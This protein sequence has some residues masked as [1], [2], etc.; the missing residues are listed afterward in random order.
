MTTFRSIAAVADA[1]AVASADR[2]RLVVGIVG[3]PGAGKSTIAEALKARIG[4]TAIVLPMDGFHLHPDLLER[5]G[6][7]ER[8]GA[9]DT[10]N[11]TAF[12]STLA[13]V[14][15]ITGE[16][17]RGPTALHVG[18][19]GVDVW[20]PGFN[21]VTE[22]PVQNAIHITPEFSTVIVEGN[23][24]LLESGGW[25][26]VA[27]LLDVTFFVDIDRGVRLQRL[28][29]RHVAF[30]KIPDDAVAWALGPDEE[31]ARLIDASAPR[32]DHAIALD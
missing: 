20:A 4:R 3:A 2:K 16:P 18:N 8:M 23:Y 11:V 28:I 24:L 12:V 7:R 17:L 31:N 6:R 1:I 27:P 14:G 13:A 29:D 25:E 15:M 19:S 5:L 10:F 26:H 30:G 22:R 9:P 32:A 21:R